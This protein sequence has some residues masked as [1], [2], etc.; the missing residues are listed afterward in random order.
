MHL[1][2]QPRLVFQRGKPNTRAKKSQSPLTSARQDRHSK[3]CPDF[4]ERRQSLLRQ[5]LLSCRMVGYLPEAQCW[6]LHCRTSNTSVQVSSQHCFFDSPTNGILKLR[7]DP[8]KLGRLSVNVSTD[9]VLSQLQGTPSPHSPNPRSASP[10]FAS[11]S[12][13]WN[14]VL[15]SMPVLHMIFS[16]KACVHR[17]STS[18]W[19]SHRATHCCSGACVRLC[20]NRIWAK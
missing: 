11:Q 18:S 14:R 6:K 3:S 15:A 16:F 13:T 9:S 12:S 7:W 2:Q 20:S 5:A 4:L 19:G 1:Q 8:A 17:A 10:A